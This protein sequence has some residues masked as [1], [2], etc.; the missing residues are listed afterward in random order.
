[1]RTKEFLS[2]HGIAFE[3]IDIQADPDGL[4]ALQALGVRTVPVVARGSDYVFGQMLKDVAAFVGVA[5]DTKPK[6]TPQELI[7]T[8]DLVV[9]AALR[10]VAQVPAPMLDQNLRDRKRPIRTLCYHIF[11]LEEVFVDVVEKE[12]TLSD[13]LLNAAPPDDIRT[14]ADIVA[15]GEVVQHRLRAW[16]ADFADK[17]CR[18]EIDSYYGRQTLHHVLER[19]TWHPAQHVRQLMMALR[20]AGI[21]PDGPIPDTAFA[22]LPLPEKVWDDETA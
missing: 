4:A 20:E 17:D 14:T 21:E 13:D 19:H 2:S 22:G 7:D 15:Y 12:I 10:F 1:L 11:H 5:Y 16:W 6:L 18:R 3:S 9:S 8:L